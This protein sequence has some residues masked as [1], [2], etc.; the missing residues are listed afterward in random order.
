MANEFKVKKG[1]IVQGSG[2][3]LLDIQGSQGQLFSVTDSLEGSL[4]SVN[5]ISGMPIMEVFSDDRVNLGTFNAE[6]IKVSG[7]TANITGSLFGTASYA[8]TALNVVNNGVTSVATNNGITGGTITS[9]GTIGL[10]TAYGDTVNPYASKTANYV[11]AA[12]NGSAGVPSF[13]AIVAADIPTL[14]QSTTGNAATATTSGLLTAE[15]NRTISPSELAANRLKFG[16]TSWTNNNNSPYADFLHLRSYQDS[17]GGPDN[18]VMFKKDGIGM[19]IWQQTYGSATAYSSYKDVAWT[20]GTNASG[21]WGIGISGNAATATKLYN[22]ATTFSG[23]YPMVVN[24]SGV[25]YSHGSI[26]FTGATG[27]VTATTFS[28]ALTGN[29]TTA[30]TWQTAR[31][32]TIGNTGKSVNGSANVAWS[33]AEIGAQAAL[34]N[35]VTGTGADN[36]VAVWSGTTTQDSDSNLTWNGTTFNVGGTLTA[37]VKSFI[38]DH[39]T[40]QGK[41]LQYGVLEGPEHSVYVR[42]KLTNNNTITLPDHWTGLVHEDT[43]TVNLTPIGKRQDLWVETVTDTTITVGSDNEINCFYTVFAERKDIEKLVTEFDK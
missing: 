1:L 21:T 29:A 11:L 38:I 8:T 41:K 18:L 39:P 26:T 4:F 2:S 42:G 43:I 31:T 36:R 9:T 35:P 6:A 12:P 34:T 23:T 3:T 33:L 24:V 22:I 32:I 30:T 7:S 5:D 16:F 20:D 27:T 13:R 14:N 25:L 10:A 15:D 40:K 37:T 28:G 17:S 19:R